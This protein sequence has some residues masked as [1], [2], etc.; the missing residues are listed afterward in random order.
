MGMELEEPEYV[1][2]EDEFDDDDDDYC[3]ECGYS[4]PCQCDRDYDNY[5]DNQLESEE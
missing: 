3:T 1:E 4:Y 2:L 5:R